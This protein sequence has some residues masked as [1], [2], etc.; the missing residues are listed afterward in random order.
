MKNL[1]AVLVFGSTVAALTM[2]AKSN[3]VPPAERGSSVCCYGAP[4]LRRGHHEV[5]CLGAW[6][7]TSRALLA[8]GSDLPADVAAGGHPQRASRKLA[9]ADRGPGVRARPRVERRRAGGNPEKARSSAAGSHALPPVAPLDRF[10]T[11]SLLLAGDEN[12]SG[13]HGIWL[14]GLCPGADRT[15]KTVF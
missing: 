5:C 8:S 4:L 14:C 3:L 7:E 10:H 1:L 2:L 13:H 9:R 11:L 6:Y 15:G 12:H